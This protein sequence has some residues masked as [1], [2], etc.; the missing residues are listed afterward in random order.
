MSEYS[1]DMDSMYDWVQNEL[2]SELIHMPL[3]TVSAFDKMQVGDSLKPDDILYKLITHLVLKHMH[4]N[5]CPYNTDHRHNWK[6]S[7]YIPMIKVA[8]VTCRK[9]VN[10]I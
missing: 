3:W 5:K 1:D 6:V 2:Y 8:L 7:Q 10:K 9:I 4:N